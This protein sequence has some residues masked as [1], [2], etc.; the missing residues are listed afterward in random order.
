MKDFRVVGP[1]LSM[2][3]L[4]FVP[5]TPL[6]AQAPATGVNVTT[7]QQDD[8]TVCT[9]GCVYRTG[10]NLKETTLT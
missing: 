10:A 6:A 4:I 1:L 9:G 5:Y 3:L 8:P 2:L 7:W